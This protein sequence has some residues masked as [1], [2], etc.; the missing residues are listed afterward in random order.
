[1]KKWWEVIASLK[2]EMISS[3]N[4]AYASFFFCILAMSKTISRYPVNDSWLKTFLQSQVFYSDIRRLTNVRLEYPIVAAIGTKSATLKYFDLSLGLNLVVC[5]VV[6]LAVTS[7]LETEAMSLAPITIE[8][9]RSSA[10]IF[11]LL[12]VCFYS[13]SNLKRRMIFSLINSMKSLVVPG[14][15]PDSM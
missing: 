10:S 12:D 7:P 15:Y 11:S 6:L 2:A 9:S 5:G 14:S 8:I 4:S 3:M 13:A 1:M